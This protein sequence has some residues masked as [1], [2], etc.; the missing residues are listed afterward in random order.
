M[1]TY[2]VKAE[3]GILKKSFLMNSLIEQYL[4]FLEG[5]IF[6][7]DK[8]YLRSLLLSDSP[9]ENFKEEWICEEGIMF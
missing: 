7:K 9:A 4:G 3:I 8:N 2:N 1:R 5:S 6:I